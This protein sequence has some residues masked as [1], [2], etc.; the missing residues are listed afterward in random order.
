MDKSEYSRE[1]VDD[2]EIVSRS[3]EG[4]L[5]VVAQPGNMTRYELLITALP[6]EA[7]KECGYSHVMSLVN[8]SRGSMGLN[9]G[10]G[11]PAP[12]YIREKMRLDETPGDAEALSFILGC[13]VR[14][15][16]L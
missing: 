6:R 7:R 8:G 1:Y 3:E 9:I 10:M 2:I 11:V 13:L 15:E 16:L 12:G 4:S 5:F 14:R